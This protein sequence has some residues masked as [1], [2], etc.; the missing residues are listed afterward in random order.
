MSANNP[1]G[2]SSF[3]QILYITRADRFSAIAEDSPPRLREGHMKLA[4]ILTALLLATVEAQASCATMQKLAQEHSNDMARSRL[5]GSCGLH[6]SRAPRRTCRERRRRRKDAKR[7][8]RIVV[9]IARPRGQHA[10]AGMQSL[11]A[12]GRARRLLLDDGYRAMTMRRGS[13]R[14]PMTGLHAHTRTSS[15]PLLATTKPL[16]TSFTRSHDFNFFMLSSQRLMLG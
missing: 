10:S 12:R 5:D 13:H 14:Q 8:D 16:K 2:H 3:A 4:I 11:G 15:F 9:G 1:G 6:G 7:G